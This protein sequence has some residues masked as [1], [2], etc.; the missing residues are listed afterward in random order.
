M[1]KANSPQ[2]STTS[3][4]SYSTNSIPCL[5]RCLGSVG[6]LS[7]PSLTEIVWVFA[8][9]PAVLCSGLYG[10][11]NADYLVA[12]LVDDMARRLDELESSLSL[13]GD[14][15]TTSTASLSAK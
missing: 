15:G 8:R 10:R 13:A 9:V 2:P 6:Y 11:D 5:G 3:L 14:A 1:P 7:S 12:R 4:T